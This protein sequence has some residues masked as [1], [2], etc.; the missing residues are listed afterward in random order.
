MSF[1]DSAD[2][3]T[4]ANALIQVLPFYRLHA[5]PEIRPNHSRRYRI[6]AYRRQLQ[7]KGACQRL[8]GSADT[9]GNNP[10]P[11]RALPGNSG[12]KHDGAALANILPSVFDR[13]QCSPIAQFKGSSGLFE[14]GSGKLLQLEAIA[15]GKYQLIESPNIR[16]ESFDGLFVR[17]IKSVPMRVSA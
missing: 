8:D 2:R 16:K 13:S 7:G 12:C 17:E 15:G 9:R 1:A 5:L 6:H 14:I 3:Q 11:M 4:V 10:S